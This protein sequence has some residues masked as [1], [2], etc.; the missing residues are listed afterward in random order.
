M[1]KGEYTG[2]ELCYKADQIEGDISIERVEGMQMDRRGQVISRFGE[3]FHTD[4]FIKG[5]FLFYELDEKQPPGLFMRVSEDSSYSA[6]IEVGHRGYFIG[7]DGNEMFIWR[8]DFGKRELWRQ[9]CLILPWHDYCIRA[10]IEGGRISVWLD[11]QLIASVYENR[12]F[13]FGRFGTGSFGSRILVKRVRYEL[14]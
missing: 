6:Q 1:E 13:P 11:G 9:R 7:F 2:L 10:Q 5:D 8:M 3:R 4:G 12:P 14:E